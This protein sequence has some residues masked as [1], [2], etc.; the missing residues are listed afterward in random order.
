MLAHMETVPPDVVC[1]GRVGLR[2]RRWRRVGPVDGGASIN[3]WKKVGNV[4]EQLRLTE[5]IHLGT[6]YGGKEK[7]AQIFQQE[8]PQSHR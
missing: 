8:R 2:G 5:F 3:A 1:S 7:K 6:D 4:L